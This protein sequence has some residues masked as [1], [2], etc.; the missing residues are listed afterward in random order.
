MESGVK[1]LGTK[2][3]VFQHRLIRIEDL[4]LTFET[5]FRCALLD[6]RTR[7]AV[8]IPDDVRAKAKAHMV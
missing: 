4:G 8:E 5:N 2:C 1:E 3:A 7:R 6:H